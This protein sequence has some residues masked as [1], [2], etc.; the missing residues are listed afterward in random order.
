MTAG[1]PARNAGRG[2]A[3]HIVAIPARQT[4]HWVS[5]RIATKE[6]PIP[7]QANRFRFDLAAS[8]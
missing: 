8:P 5:M 4:P 1:D 6:I 7:I 3:C 2:A